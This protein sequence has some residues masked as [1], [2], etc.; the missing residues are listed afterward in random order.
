MVLNLRPTVRKTNPI[1]PRTETMSQWI[2][3]PIARLA[4]IAMVSTTATAMTENANAP[5]Q[6]RFTSAEFIFFVLFYF[7]LPAYC[8]VDPR[9]R[10]LGV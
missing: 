1:V 5:T 9:W 3:L 10:A 7:G 6:L 8:S 4:T 2:T